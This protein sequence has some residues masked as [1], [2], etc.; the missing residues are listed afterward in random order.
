[1]RRIRITVAYDG[2]EFHGWQ[3]Q[4]ALP[5][6]QGWLEQILT[7]IESAPVQVHGS[8]RTDAGV[9]AL[10]QVAA[11]DLVN[12]I[13]C[14]NLRRA[15][16]RLLPRSIRVTSVEE[17]APD[18]HPRFQAKEKT[19]EY[20][21][22]REEICP[23]MRRLYV[24]HHPYPLDET[25]MI[26]AAPLLVG[27]HDFTAFAATDEKDELGHSKVRR[28]FASGLWREG[29]ELVYRVRGSGFL[30]HMVRMIVG[31]LLEVGKGNLTEAGLQA[32]LTPG[33]PAKAGPCVP[34]SGL[35]LLNVEY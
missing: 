26:A 35:C 2:T 27:D 19:Y 12:P 34:A 32:R 20:R 22:W 29:G 6:I 5:T 23:P 28:I 10:A 25:A 18:F 31:T 21:I 15:V 9:H 4:P 30:K 17:A 14:D 7:G 1:M 11:F 3:V 24:F 16:N 8:G 33:F 13:P